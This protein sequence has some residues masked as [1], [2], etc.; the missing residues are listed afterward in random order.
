VS[1]EQA[2]APRPAA[3]A[4]LRV[5]MALAA[6]ACL[7]PTPGDIGGCGAPARNLDA[8]RFFAVKQKFDCQGCHRCGLLTEACA[9]A[10]RGGLTATDG[11]DAQA[12]L[13]PELC[14]P[15]VHDGQVCLRALEAASCDEYRRYMA[16]VEPEVPTECNFCPL[17]R[18]PQ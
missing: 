14:Y 5:F 13:F 11:G 1:R 4:R 2:R 15:L 17:E 10:C 3:S 9:V 6:L 8:P 7:A 16:D 12:P 18:G